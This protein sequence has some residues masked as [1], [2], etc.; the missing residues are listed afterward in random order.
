MKKWYKSKTLIF[1]A[2]TGVVTVAMV[3]SEQ[4]LSPK[5]LEVM[6]TI[7][8]IGNIILRFKTVD[9]IKTRKRGIEE[10]IKEAK[11]TAKDYTDKLKEDFKKSG[12]K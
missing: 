10:N 2:V 5:M 1:N 12:K 3:L 6:G 11:E 8:A 7:A 4:N 9:P